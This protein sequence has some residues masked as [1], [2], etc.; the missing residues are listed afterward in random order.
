MK[1]AVR[2]RCVPANHHIVADADLQFAEEDRIGEIAIIAD[3]Q[4]TLRFQSEVR[5]IHCAGRANSN[6]GC[7]A[8][9]VGSGDQELSQDAAFECD[10]LADDVSSCVDR[11][12][13]AS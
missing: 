13:S 12:A 9:V 11:L 6:L 1:V 7:V 8:G 5:A 2:D 10:R 4:P 3:N